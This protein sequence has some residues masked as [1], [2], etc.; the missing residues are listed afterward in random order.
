MCQIHTSST[1]NWYIFILIF[2]RSY[3][4][5]INSWST[6]SINFSNWKRAPRQAV[7]ILH[8][9]PSLNVTTSMNHQGGRCT[10]KAKC[11]KDTLVLLY[12]LQQLLK[13]QTGVN[14]HGCGSVTKQ[15]IVQ[16]ATLFIMQN[17]FIQ[18]V[19]QKQWIDFFKH[20]QRTPIKAK[21]PATE[22]KLTTVTGI[23]NLHLEE[24]SSN[25]NL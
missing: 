3:R 17:I 8:H 18:T 22:Y 6:P 13:S 21:T 23:T 25:W 20:A 24:S 9:I 14:M 19:R 2:H 11:L 10:W 1:F 12:C 15:H 7:L 4:W 5:N 16:G